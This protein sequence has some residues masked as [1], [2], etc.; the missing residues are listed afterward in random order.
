MNNTANT[1]PEMPAI[2]AWNSPGLAMT[3]VLPV[4]CRVA[5]AMGGPL[6]TAGA[7]DRPTR[8]SFPAGTPSPAPVVRASAVPGQYRDA[9]Y[10]AR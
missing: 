7:R 5:A 8:S 10:R 1:T 9:P 3:G 6:G 4:S 2:R